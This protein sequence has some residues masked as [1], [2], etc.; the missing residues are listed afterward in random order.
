MRHDAWI[1]ESCGRDFPPS[2]EEFGDSFRIE[3]ASTFRRRWRIVRAL[4]LFA[5]LLLSG[6]TSGELCAQASTPASSHAT[7]A[8]LFDFQRPLPEP[9][10]EALQGEL[11]RN[12][13]SAWPEQPMR[14]MERQ[15]FQK[16][17]EFPE[18]IQ[19][20]LQGHCNADL[21]TDWQFAEGPLGWV[22]MTDGEIQPIAY[23][24]CDRIGQTLERELRGANSRV[25][26]EKFAR[27][28]SRVVAHELTHIFTQ[29]AHH[30]PRGLQRAYL[31]AGELTN[32][33]ML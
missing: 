31:T 20:R 19:V 24:N 23:V 22:Y 13:A 15:Q 1:F 6:K 9:F 5:A 27:A 14:W 28:I 30:G 4:I 33:R 29:S 8:V 25:R 2:R 32:D 10:W 17:M 11:D 7:T 21:T 3:S 26:Q 16:G 18:V 12:A